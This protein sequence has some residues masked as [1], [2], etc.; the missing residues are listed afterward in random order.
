MTVKEAIARVSSSRNLAE[1]EMA[2]V[3]TEIMDGQAT[4]AQIG[5]LLTALHIKGETV[6]EISGA[7]Q[8]MRALATKVQS[9][10]KV[11]DTCGTGGDGCRTFNISTAAA[12]VAAAAG[13]C[14]AKHGNRAM[15]GA[16]GGADVLE[17]L[18]ARIELN[19]TQVERCLHEVRFGFLLAPAFHRAMR[20][21]V[22]PRREI[23]IRTIFNLLGPLTNPAG[24]RHQLLGVF[25][26]RWVT[27]LAEALG[28]LGS[29]HALVVHGEDGLDEIS[30]TGPTFVAEWYAGAVRT[31]TLIPEEFGFTC[32]QLTDLQVA[33][34]EESA[35]II[36][37]VLMGQT[38]PQRDIILLN[39]GAALYAGDA[40]SSIAL[41]VE[42]ARIAIDTGA[43]AQ[44]L[45]RFVALTQTEP[46][47]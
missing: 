5:A 15:S 9:I 28:R 39:A 23:G 6:A 1:E 17:T 13:L 16:V 46:P 47:V 8:V 36:R 44:T 30:L 20:H 3:M 21:A 32:C 38:G 7:A 45:E 4:P 27:P 29:S 12:L 34:A 35:A 42:R 24:A 10:G 37:S 25:A 43:A 33:S 14:V 26:K 18:G 22:G 31:F 41:G 19:P 11:L 2:G 40:V